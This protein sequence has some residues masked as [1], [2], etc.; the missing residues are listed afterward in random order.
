MTGS[1]SLD[2]YAAAWN[3]SDA[4]KRAAHLETAW[5]VDGVYCDPTARVTGRDALS[6]HIGSLRESLG[7]FEIT[8]TSA[9]D[10]HHGFVHWRWRMTKDSGEPM[11][12]GFDVAQIDDNGQVALIVGFFEQVEGS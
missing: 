11:I 5:A 3:E 12:D 10:E 4:A 1:V 9:Y 2:A 6:E 8:S 7:E